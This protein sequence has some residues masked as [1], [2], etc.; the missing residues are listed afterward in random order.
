MKNKKA[1]KVTVIVLISLI[2]AVVIAALAVFN[3]VVKPK[4][5]QIAGIMNEVVNDEEI[6]KE[7]E[8]Y[9]DNDEMVRII[10]Q[11]ET[12][13]TSEELRQKAKEYEE[14]KKSDEAAEK[15]ESS[16]AP[17]TDKEENGAKTGGSTDTKAAT[18]TIKKPAS[19]YSSKY[20][21]VK[22]NV[23]TSDFSKGTALA[24]KIDTGYVLGLLS[25]GLTSEEKTELKAYLKSRLSSAEIAE[26][27]SLYSKYSYLLK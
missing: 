16:S 15:S 26:G 9:L 27:I 8:P 23:N 3:F 21:Y 4:A 22:D 10:E 5:K 20:E 11:L 24:S 25:R 12:D 17:D 2:L 13:G 6:L 19:A 14:R 7:I 18:K 1:L